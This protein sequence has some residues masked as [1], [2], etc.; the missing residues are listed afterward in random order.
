MRALHTSVLGIFKRRKK[1]GRGDR[2]EGTEEGER[3][4]EKEGER[5][6]G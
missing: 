6:G 1:M 5:E 4:G 3:E 2:R